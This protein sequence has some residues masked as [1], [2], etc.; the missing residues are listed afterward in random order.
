[1]TLSASDTYGAFVVKIT[2]ATAP[3]ISQQPQSRTV[4]LGQPATFTVSAQGTEPLSFQWRRDG[5]DISGATS[6][7]YTL[8]AA[9]STDAGIYSVIVRNAGGIATSGNAA[10]QVVVPEAGTVALGGAEY[11]VAENASTLQVQVTRTGATSSSATVELRTADDTAI[12][13]VDYVSTS[14]GVRF[15][16][17]ETAKTVS[18]GLIDDYYWEP[19]ESFSLQLCNAGAGVALGSP[20]LALVVITDNDVQGAPVITR[21]PESHVAPQGSGVEFFVT[22]VGNTPLTYEWWK[23]GTALV[24][25]TNRWLRIGAVQPSDEGNYSVRVRNDA[26]EAISLVA[27]LTVIVPPVIITAPQDQTV[28]CGESAS[29]SIRVAQ[30]GGEA[31]VPPGDAF[32]Y[33]WLKDGSEIAGA[34]GPEITLAS[35]DFGDAGTYTVIATDQNGGSVSASAVLSVSGPVLRIISANGELQFQWNAS[36]YR[37]QMTTDPVNGPWQELPGVSG[38][39]RVRATQGRQ[40][41]RL[42]QD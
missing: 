34:A 36:D 25:A 35:V 39:V 21:Q 8:D 13:G 3:E 20:S 40:F 4:N 15:A 27:R 9:K 32:T 1:M 10:L 7:S 42:V 14:V 17:G 18:L 6:A 30:A 41:F 5:C 19:S 16:P 37:V 11:A 22:V 38:E 24:G 23:D 28:S 26:G 2:G 31:S 29:F 33:R 12:G